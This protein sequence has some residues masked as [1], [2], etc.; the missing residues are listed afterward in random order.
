MH[1]PY[2]M[3]LGWEILD[4]ALYLHSFILG[5]SLDRWDRNPLFFVERGKYKACHLSCYGSRLCHHYRDPPVWPICVLVCRE[6]VLPGYV[7]GNQRVPMKPAWGWLPP[8]EQCSGWSTSLS[9]SQLLSSCHRKDW[10]KRPKQPLCLPS[11]AAN[12]RALHRNP[13]H[14]LPNRGRVLSSAPFLWLSSRSFICWKIL[15]G[16]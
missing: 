8:L 15:L 5:H 2:Q 1:E 14:G 9:A 4:K 16:F 10:R 13:I 3:T 7:R 6:A 12:E 11:L